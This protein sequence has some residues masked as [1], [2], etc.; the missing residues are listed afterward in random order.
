MRPRTRLFLSCHVIAAIL[1]SVHGCTS[2]RSELDQL[3]PFQPIGKQE[4]VAVTSD[5][6]SVKAGD[7]VVATVEKG[8]RLGVIER[9]GDQVEVQVCSD[10][11]LRRGYLLI[12]D[13]KFLSDDD[14][15]LVAEWLEMTRDLD[16]G[17]DVAACGVKLRALVER[18]AAAAAAGKTPRGKARLIG[19][20]L[21]QR[22]RLVYKQDEKRLDRLLDL[23]QG[24][25]FSFSMVYLCIAQRLKMPLFLVTVPEHGLVRYD[26][27]G[28]RFNIE[29]T[30]QGRLFDTDD[31]LRC[32]WNGRRPRHKQLGG[33]D[34]ASQPIPTA[35]STLYGMTGEALHKMGRSA[36]ACEKHAKAIEIN[37]RCT[38]A[39]YNWGGALMKLDKP[40]KACEK[41]ARAVEVNPRC[42]PANYNWGVALAELHKAPEAME[43]AEKAA[44]LDPDLR[45]KVRKLRELLEE[46]GLLASG[47]GPA[48]DG[49][50][51]SSAREEPSS[52]DAGT[53]AS[54]DPGKTK[55]VDWARLQAGKGD[56][57]PDKGLPIVRASLE[58]MGRQ[59]A[60]TVAQKGREVTFVIERLD[61][62]GMTFKMDVVQTQGTFTINASMPAMGLN[63]ADVTKLRIKTTS[64]GKE[65]GVALLTDK[66]GHW[67]LPFSNAPERDKLLSALTVLCEHL[68]KE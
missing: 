18:V 45:P 34:L 14:I 29:T 17:I 11:D 26:D 5:R 15:D 61:R 19:E 16:P 57:T 62:T 20:H 30:G 28:E 10:N 35:L 8:R 27:A 63:F 40:A 6:A 24:D 37:P 3:P 47:S 60:G 53:S 22:E 52:S 66:G 46:A 23:R 36:E 1:F 33:T 43:K 65:T 56:M 13:V 42:A 51:G 7:Q 21:F 44:R 31:F 48:Q 58:R 25:C 32:D 54:S 55:D 12:S 67:D 4:T 68:T 59:L 2:T 9:R 50:A 38:E 41:Y 49:H 39:Y 64:A